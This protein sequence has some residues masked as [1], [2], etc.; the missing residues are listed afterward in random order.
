MKLKLTTKLPITLKKT[1]LYIFLSL[2][3]TIIASTF[4]KAQFGGN[5]LFEYQYG[6]I[7]DTDP[8]NLNSLYNQTN[9]TY[10]YKKINVRLRLEQFYNSNVSNRNYISLSQYYFRYR[11]KKIRLEVGTIYETL[12][13]GLVFRT[14]EIKNS[15]LED[16]IYRVRTGF[17]RDL[18]GASFTYKGKIGQVK[19]IGGRP[20]DNQYPPGD[21][22]RRTDFVTG[23]EAYLKI[24]KQKIGGILLRNTSSQENA[25]YGSLFVDGNITNNFTYYGEYAGILDY[26]NKIA[27]ENK[28]EGHG[29]YLGLNYTFQKAGLSLEFKDY[30]NF[31]LGSGFTAPPTLVKEHTYKVLN[32]STHVSDLISEKGIQTELFYLLEGGDIITFN[33]S[34]T[35]NNVVSRKVFYEYFAEYSLSRF[36]SFKAKFFLDYSA[37]DLYLE[38]NRIAGGAYLDQNIGKSTISLNTEVQNF[39]RVFAE[40]INIWNTFTGLNWNYNSKMTLSFFWEFSTDPNV[41]DRKGTSEIEERR[42]FLAGQIFYRINEKNSLTLFAGQRRG[43]PACSSG[44]CYEV[45]DFEGVELRINSRF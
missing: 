11:N 5:N 22:L 4:T 33:Y 19:L 27:A 32:R 30:K 39:D 1:S 24:K 43:G 34:Q 29:L 20:L 13:R 26:Q 9:L 41:T 21:S 44:I 25:V 28:N 42:H 7:P 36:K 18:Q 37:D 12:G 23:T 15:I 40:T 6:N 10:K 31:F 38:K 8:Y 17:Y 2:L 14:Y 16:R 3:L 35:V 45:L